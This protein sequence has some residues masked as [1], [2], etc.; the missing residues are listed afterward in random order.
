MW[1]LARYSYWA[2]SARSNRHPA[3]RQRHAGVSSASFHN[4]A[5]AP[6]ITVLHCE[7]RLNCAGAGVDSCAQAKHDSRNHVCWTVDPVSAIEPDCNAC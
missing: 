6:V 5:D 7:C 2:N 4:A 1:Y 3:A